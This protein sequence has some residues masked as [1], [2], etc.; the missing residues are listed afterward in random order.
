MSKLSSVP[1]VINLAGRIRGTVEQF[2]ERERALLAEQSDRANKVELRQGN[3]AIE[4]EAR[5]QSRIQDV[6]ERYDQACAHCDAMHHARMG[7]IE[8][9]HQNLAS[10][11]AG[12]NSGAVDRARY[13]SQKES[14]EASKER[15]AGTKAA[16]TALSAFQSEVAAESARVEE[17]ASSFR[18]QAGAYPDLLAGFD[19]AAVSITPPAEA[20]EQELLGSAREFAAAAQTDAEAF[21]TYAL[22]RFFRRISLPFVIALL[23]LTSGGAAYAVHHFGL[24]VVL[25]QVIGGLFLVAIGVFSFLNA[26]ARARNSTA[27]AHVAD[28]LANAREHLDAADRSAANRHALEIKRVGEAYANTIAEWEGALEEAETIA[29]NE[30]AANEEILSAKLDRAISRNNN[31]HSHRLAAAKERYY[32]ELEAA[33]QQSEREELEFASSTNSVSIR[34]SSDQTTK[35]NAL[36]AEWEDAWQSLTAE[37][38]SCLAK[39]R[40]LFPEWTPE[41]LQNWVPPAQFSLGAN[42]GQL[43]IDTSLLDETLAADSHLKPPGGGAIALPL[44]LRLPDHGSLILETKDTPPAAVTEA[45]NGVILRLLSSAPAGRLSFTIIDPVGLGQNFAGIMHLADYEDSLI[46]GRIWTETSQIEARLKDLNEH[47]EKVI[48]MYLRNEYTDIAEYNEKAGNIAEKYHFVVVADFPTGFSEVAAKRLQS[49]ATS[50]A[51]CG[52]YSL[53]HWDHRKR[54]PQ[55]F[56]PEDLRKNSI[57]L[58]VGETASIRHQVLPGTALELAGPPP[59]DQVIDFIHRLGKGNKD[60]NRIEVPFEHIA[61]PS[62]RLWT[63]STAKE[64]RVAIGRTGATKFQYL[65]IGRD[66][67]QHALV[68]GKTGSGKSTLF[69][70]AITNLALWCSPDEVE[71][72]L[73]DFKKGVEFRCYARH[74]LPHARVIAIESDREFGLS[75]LQRVDEELKRRGE[76]F[77]QLGVQDLAGYRASGAKEPMPRSL[78]LIDEFQEFFTED[79]RIAQ[80]AASLLD[81]IV[82]QGRAFGIHVILGSQT[83]GGAHTLPRPTMGQ[84]VVRIALACNEADSYIILDDSNPAARHLH[85]PGEGIYNDAAGAIAGNSPFQVVWLPDE[86]RD[87]YL[88]LVN[89]QA[90]TVG[91]RLPR[92]IV[93]EGNSPA[94]ITEN[95]ELAKL[96]ASPAERTPQPVFYLGAPNAIKGPTRA[97][98]A[99]QSGA[100]LMIVGQ[101]DDATQA[102]LSVGL[103]GLAGQFAKD[104]VK[105]VFIDGSVPETP[106]RS[107]LDHAVAALPYE[108]LR[109]N[110]SGIA[111]AMDDLAADLRERTDNDTGHSGPRTFLIV[112]GLQKFKKLRHEDD[113]SFS[114][115]DS[116]GTNPGAN[117][118]TLI[119]E[120][121]T[122]GIHVIIT[123]DTLNNI[124]RCLSRKAQSEFEMSVLYQMSANDSASLIDS[125]AAANLGLHRALFHNEQ[126]GHLETFRPYAP[127]EAGWFNNLKVSNE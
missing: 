101:R 115:D 18:K 64:L 19:T 1:E 85:R 104:Q 14:L 79:D 26:K 118:D 40:A 120:G 52:V 38:E 21:D 116:A 106:E 121:P 89:Q 6:T 13:L 9:A 33:N 23:T 35:L 54:L 97:T 20:D 87:R 74:R 63:D 83:L 113:F 34:L 27:I 47:M 11:V 17:I 58:N 73:I 3:E 36:E 68:A 56:A 76:I 67:C 92:P 15:D 44:D 93:F 28:H 41:Y 103:A 119:T 96:L 55:D 81:R 123:I 84:M 126:L 125:P 112:H 110:P 16:A 94:D 25:Y 105:V 100:N 49:I 48:Q 50:G 111:T 108:V 45:L 117:L 62:D 5:R 10:Q 70:V 124:N 107:Y 29:D 43:V 12:A 32:E 37:I 24:D 95:D 82:R 31:L 51:R 88:Q 42:F 86:V 66:T 91:S 75:V 90:E 46:N 80:N 53:I 102:L 122:H 30:R 127:P 61:P 22:P 59:A 114:L 78:L 71:F 109:P 77:R 98:F 69:H 72:Y 65:S 39:H 57:S 8:Q 60:S 4:L 7:R 99:R 2:A